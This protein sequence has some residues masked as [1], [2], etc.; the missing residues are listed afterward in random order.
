MPRT[1]SGGLPIQICAVGRPRDCLPVEVLDL[2]AALPVTGVVELES[3]AGG[4]AEGLGGLTAGG[5]TISF[6]GAGGAAFSLGVGV[7]R[8]T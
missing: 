3:S 7:G 1:S 8:G 4:G 2:S 5:G 6:A